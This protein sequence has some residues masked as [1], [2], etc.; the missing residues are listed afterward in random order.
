MTARR[1]LVAWLAFM[2]AATVLHADGGML[3]L[4]QK[5][6]PFLVSV[7]TFPEV[8]RAGPVDVSVLVQDQ[9]T[10]HVLL[11]SFVDLRFEPPAGSGAP[12]FVRASHAQAT[13]KLLQAATVDLPSAGQWGVHIFVRRGQDHATLAMELPVARATPQLSAV[14]PYLLLPLVVIL[15]FALRQSRR[16]TDWFVTL[17]SNCLSERRNH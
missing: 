3:R 16:P 9:R 1:C 2:L 15:L 6:G 8:L 4:R 10:G 12:I 13:N 5:S 11:D 14:W 7:F 17:T